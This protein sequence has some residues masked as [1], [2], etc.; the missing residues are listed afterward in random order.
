MMM[1]IM[2]GRINPPKGYE[3]TDE[4]FELN[5]EFVPTVRKVNLDESKRFFV[6][7]HSDRQYGR[8]NNLPR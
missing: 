3:F 8:Q 1:T 6:N 5:G 2:N 7:N 4:Y